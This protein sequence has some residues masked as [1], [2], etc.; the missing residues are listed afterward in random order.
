MSTLIVLCGPQAS[1]KTYLAKRF[2]KTHKN[3]KIVS[4]DEIRFSM[5]KDSDDYFKYEPEVIKRFYGDINAALK[6]Y[7]YV[8][9]DATHLTKKSRNALFRH[10]NLKNVY[11]VGFWLESNLDTCLERNAKRSGRKKVPEE[12]IKDSFRR[13]VSPQEDEIFH[14]VYFFASKQDYAIG[15]KDPAIMSIDDILK[16]I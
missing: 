9:A 6:V 8:I 3:C 14:D 16:V 1:G 15:T 11:I 5:I 10:L 13:K 7:D 4:R 12:V 2:A